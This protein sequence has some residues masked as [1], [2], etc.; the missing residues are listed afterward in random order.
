LNPP[1]P[2]PD[3]PEHVAPMGSEVA[4]QRTPRFR[5]RAAG[6]FVQRPGC[7]DFALYALGNT[8]I[9]ALC[10]N[11]CDY[12]GDERRRIDRIE[13]VRIRPQQVPNE[14]VAGLIEDPWRSFDCPPDPSGCVVEFEDPGFNRD[15]VYYVRALEQPTPIINAGGL[16]C[17]TDET[18]EC[19]AVDACHQN[20]ET[21]RD[22][23]CLAESQPRAWSSP[24]YVDFH[25]AP[26]GRSLEPEPAPVRIPSRASRVSMVALPAN[27]RAEPRTGFR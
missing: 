19:V 17:T 3:H 6:S 7:P 18:G 4:M 9:E 15:S 16:R 10:A 24:I 20:F 27:G 5:V 12:P 14:P 22:D 13:V 11:E 2:N 26:G 25:Q 1:V 8:R 21:E 23:D